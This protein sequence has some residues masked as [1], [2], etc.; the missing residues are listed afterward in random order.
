[1]VG[2][3]SEKRMELPIG[4]ISDLIKID[5]YADW[6][7]TV[8]PTYPK[9]LCVIASLPSDFNLAVLK[10]VF[11]QSVPV[12]VIVLLPKKISGET[13]VEKVSKVLN[14]GLQHIKLEDFDYIL[15][16]DSDTVLPP[17]FLEENLKGK[18]DLCGGAGY[19][20]VI[21]T[22]TFLRIMKGKFHPKSDDSYTCYKFMKENCNVGKNRVTP[23]LLR[24]S[25][26]HHG[27]TYFFNRGKAMYRL[28]YE[29]FHVLA[30]FRW[31]LGNIFAVFGYF[32]ALLKREKKFDVADFVWR[33]QVRMLLFK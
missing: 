7:I 14:D 23:I 32:A 15:R 11:Q 33:K 25:G 5:E 17:S 16:V 20:M 21:K 27:I 19:A 8:Y 10:S 2:I 9:I 4:K 18:P 26:K 30:S 1:M 28:G 29:P 6:Q 24:T 13:V 31:A 12:D 22:S 3:L